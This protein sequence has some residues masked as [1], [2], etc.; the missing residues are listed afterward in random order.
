MYKLWL[1]WFYYMSSFVNLSNNNT[2]QH[3]KKFSIDI[4]RGTGKSRTIK[5]CI[6]IHNTYTNIYEFDSY[7]FTC[8]NEM[9]DYI[10]YL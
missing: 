1:V 2:F 5:K 7:R 6:A 3:K 9:L 4:V 10:L 8:M